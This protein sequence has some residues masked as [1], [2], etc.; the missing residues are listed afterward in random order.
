MINTL[1]SYTFLLSNKK[2]LF[3]LLS[4]HLLVSGQQRQEQKNQGKSD[5]SARFAGPVP[6]F[7]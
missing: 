2:V 3:P 5:R 6:P 1:S 7:V 4:T